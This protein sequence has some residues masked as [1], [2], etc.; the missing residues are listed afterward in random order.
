M[1][2]FTQTETDY[3]AAV[4]A[5]DAIR[6]TVSGEYKLGSGYSLNV[7]MKRRGSKI[8]IEREFNGKNDLDKLPDDIARKYVET[9]DLIERWKN[10]ELPDFPDI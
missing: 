6:D 3:I 7:V 2:T 9:I 5:V 1:P 4:D 8:S 10:D